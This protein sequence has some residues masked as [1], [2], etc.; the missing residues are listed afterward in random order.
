MDWSK[1]K[2]ILIIAFI[3]TNI[4]LAYMLF[5]MKQDESEIVIE[6]EFVEEVIKLLE[7]KDIKIAT[8]IP[9]SISKLPTIYLE[10]EVY[11]PEEILPRFLGSY[12]DMAIG[13]KMYTN[14]EKTI[15]FER[16]DKKLVYENKAITDDR[17]IKEMSRK[18][19]LKMSEEFIINHGFDLKDVKLESYFEKD[20]IYRLIYNKKI[21]DMVIEE[22]Y[23]TLELSSSGVMSFERYWTRNIEKASQRLVVSSAP[24]SLLRLLTREEYYGKTIKQIDLCYYFNVDEYKRSISLNDSTGGVASPAWRFIFEDGEKLFLDEN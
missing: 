21:D 18:Q 7:K 20:N 16:N 3:V 14:G 5:T 2:S 10:Y 22:T 23:M 8:K 17:N 9:K 13:A 4:F 1:A 15:K 12:Q 11:K 19:V 24:K 6:D